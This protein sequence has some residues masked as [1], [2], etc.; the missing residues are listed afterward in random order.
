MHS[1]G[2]SIS[3]FSAV[4]RAFSKQAIRYDEFDQANPILTE[5]RALVREHVLRYI[6]PSASIL[7]LNAG[8][9]LDA[10]WFATRGYS[11]HATDISPGMIDQIDRKSKRLDTAG[12]I[13]VQRCSFENLQDCTRKNFDYVFSNFGGLNCSADLTRVANALPPLLNRGAIITWVIMPKIC[14]WEWLGILRGKPR[15]AFRRLSPEGAQANVE[16]EQFMTYYYSR[17]Q[18]EKA[19]GRRF[20]LICSQGLGAVSPP[21]SSINFIKNHPRLAESLKSLDKRLTSLFPFNR[22]ADHLIVT[23]QFKG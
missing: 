18:V 15:T 8:T 3:D 5:W 20:S 16:G 2:L 22:W 6:K 23:F 10:S 4:Q 21:P 14:P 12:R 13:T 19:L 1:T 7:E 17:R 11:V 9:G